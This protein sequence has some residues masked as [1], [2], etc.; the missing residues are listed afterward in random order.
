MPCEIKGQIGQARLESGQWVLCQGCGGVFIFDTLPFNE[1][2]YIRRMN[3]V[4]VYMFTQSEYGK[5]IKE[6]RLV[7]DRSALN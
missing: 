3:E 4:E 2:L 5:H 6:I 1:Q 7:K